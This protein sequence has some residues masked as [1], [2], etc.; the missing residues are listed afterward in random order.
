[1]EDNSNKPKTP[2]DVYRMIYHNKQCSRQEISQS[3]GISLPTT[4]QN[5]N[6]LLRTGMVYNAGE[7]KST[8]GRR[9]IIYQCVPDARFAMGIDITKNHLSIV[10]IDLSLNI[11]DSQRMR[12]SF[13]ESEDYFSLLKSTLQKMIEKN[14][15][16]PSCLLGIGLSLPAIIGSDHKSITYATVIPLSPNLYQTISKYIPAPFLFFNDANSA[17]LAESWRADYEGSVI[18]LSLSSSVG[19]ANMNGKAIYA[20]DNNRGCEFGHIT[21]MPHGKKCY[22]GRYGCLDAY[23]SSNVLSD[24]TEGNLRDFF[25]QMDANAGL[26]NV[27]DEYLDHL[28]IAVNNLRM[29]YDCDIILGGNVGAYMSDYIEIFRQKAINLNPFERDGSFIHV[30]HYRS[31]ASAVGAALYYI[32]Q[33]IQNY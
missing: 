14:I 21:I 2:G 24:F 7:F 25:S 16:D 19:G 10:L 28:A 32:D 31:E 30:C 17:G 12:I 11:I 29:C 23:C 18:Y 9:P 33:F 13:V 4:T 3:L 27:F 15:P 1:M 26:Q 22:C 8:G 6:E 20:G 5:L